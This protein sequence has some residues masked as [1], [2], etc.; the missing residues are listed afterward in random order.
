MDS[1]RMT[2]ERGHGIEN[3]ERFLTYGDIYFRTET[4]GNTDAQ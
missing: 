4:K 2:K 3:R 1:H